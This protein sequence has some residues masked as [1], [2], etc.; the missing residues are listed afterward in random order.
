MMAETLSAYINIANCEP[1]YNNHTNLT[2]SY[3]STIEGSMLTFRCQF[4]LNPND[5]HTAVCHRN[6]SWIP[7]PAQHRCTTQIVLIIFNL[8][9]MYLIHW[10][11]LKF[12][13]C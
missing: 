11:L 7:D 10:L 6:A 3:N 8:A 5:T 13:N 4:E 1:P 12:V 9:L 2:M